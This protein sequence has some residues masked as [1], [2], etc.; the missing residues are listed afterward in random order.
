[1]TTHEGRLR[2]MLGPESKIGWNLNDEDRA[3][4]RW[5]LDLVV[6]KSDEA[7]EARAE[8]VREL[9]RTADIPEPRP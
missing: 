9:R 7:A 2:A 8:F 3:A 5:I 4:I 6:Q 1:M